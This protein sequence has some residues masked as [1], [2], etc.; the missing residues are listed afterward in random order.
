[1]TNA[2]I[3][4]ELA[5]RIRCQCGRKSPQLD[6]SDMYRCACGAEYTISEKQSLVITVKAIYPPVD[7]SVTKGRE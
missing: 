6:T 7:M 3:L 1:M 4:V 2:N 5:I